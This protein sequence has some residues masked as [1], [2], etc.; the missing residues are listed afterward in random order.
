LFRWNNHA[1]ILDAANANVNIADRMVRLASRSGGD[2]G[3]DAILA[4]VFYTA[5]GK[6]IELP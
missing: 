4:R 5:L 6:L 2:G 3:Q 1:V